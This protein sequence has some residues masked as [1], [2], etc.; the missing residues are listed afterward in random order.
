MLNTVVYNLDILFDWFLPSDTVTVYRSKL[1]LLQNI[2][3]VH[4]IRTY[5]YY[6]ILYYKYF[7]NLESKVGG[8]LQAVR[9][10]VS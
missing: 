10:A 9:A 5:T 6:T 2:D 7:R 8:I 1:C 4:S 3:S